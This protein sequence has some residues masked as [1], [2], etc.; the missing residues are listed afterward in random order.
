MKN[1]AMIEIR[2]ND[3]SGYNIVRVRSFQAYRDK[4]KQRRKEYYETHREQIRERERKRRE[5]YA[6]KKQ[7]EL[8]CHSNLKGE[9]H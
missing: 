9:L 5:N 6:I 7:S 1:D 4:L 2:V 3:G 8:D